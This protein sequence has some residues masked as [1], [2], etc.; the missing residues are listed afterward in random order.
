MKIGEMIYQQRKKL[1][2]TLED[3]GKACGVPRSTVSRWEN[4]VIKKISRSNQEAL[5]T[6]LNI[7]PIMFFQREEVLTPEEMRMLK[8]YREADERAKADA[9]SMLIDHKAKKEK[10]LAI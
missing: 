2:L 3:V 9:L 7:D 8:A 4:G 10:S 5:C 1:N 6:L